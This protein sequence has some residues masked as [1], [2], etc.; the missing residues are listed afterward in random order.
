MT[1]NSQESRK[2]SFTE[3]L[4]RIAASP[5]SGAQ[6]VEAAEGLTAQRSRFNAW[7]YGRKGSA[8]T[9]E[10]WHIAA[11]AGRQRADVDAAWDALRAAPTGEVRDAERV[12]LAALLRRLGEELHEVVTTGV[13]TYQDPEMPAEVDDWD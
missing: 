7:A 9:S 4:T 1:V 2:S 3:L 12:A 10:L 6:V 8:T 13:N 5:L 11:L